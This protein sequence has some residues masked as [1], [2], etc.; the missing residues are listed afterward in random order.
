MTLTDKA[1]AKSQE[2]YTKAQESKAAAEAAD[3]RVIDDGRLLKAVRGTLA[4]YAEAYKDR[5]GKPFKMLVDE[6]SLLHP[7]QEHWQEKGGLLFRIDGDSRTRTRAGLAPSC[8]LWIEEED[9][10]QAIDF[11]LEYDDAFDDMVSCPR[12]TV[13]ELLPADWE[14]LPAEE[15]WESPA[16][17]ERREVLP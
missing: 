15:Q 13:T 5:N 9:P 1:I 11:A 3:E 16:I 14:K 17:A 6:L 4:E 12:L 10:D 8:L 7:M 2:D